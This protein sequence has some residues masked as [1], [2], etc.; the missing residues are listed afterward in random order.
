MAKDYDRSSTTE[1]YDGGL[2]A[3]GPQQ[4][5]RTSSQATDDFVEHP[6]TLTG[7]MSALLRSCARSHG[8]DDTTTVLPLRLC[9]RGRVDTTTFIVL[10]LTAVQR[11]RPIYGCC[12]EMTLQCWPWLALLL[13]A[14]ACRA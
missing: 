3:N 8:R 10:P 2:V 14:C 11:R 4:A 1:D 12:K 13:G 6:G 5:L 7:N 9:C